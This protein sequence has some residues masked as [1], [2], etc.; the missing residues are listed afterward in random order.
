MSSICQDQVS[1][2]VPLVKPH[3][4]MT[5]QTLT[6]WMK[7]TLT[8]AGVESNVWKPHTVRSAAVAHLKV[9]KNLD[10]V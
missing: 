2:F 1:F 10:L 5:S 6:R 9:V 7:S 3:K 8:A 4:S